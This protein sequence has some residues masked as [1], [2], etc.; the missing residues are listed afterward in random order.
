MFGTRND[1]NG[2]VDVVQEASNKIYVLEDCAQAYSGRSMATSAGGRADLSLYSFGTIK[3]ST[4][5]G[6]AMV[7]VRDGKLYD[8]MKALN[9]TYP[10]R[11]R[12]YF[13]KRVVKYAA[14]HSATSPALFGLLLHVCLKL[15]IPHDEVITA[16]IRGFSGG[17]LTDLIRCR[18]SVPLLALL[19]R[20]L[21][22]EDVEYINARRERSQALTER[23][24]NIPGVEVCR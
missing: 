18:P 10:V 2:I 19:L 6:G 20:R 12:S 23:L 3:T 15:N 8:D 9:A 17:E 7:S 24:Q 5:F 4:A 21:T 1:I 22:N 13:L 11:P 14:V 16:A